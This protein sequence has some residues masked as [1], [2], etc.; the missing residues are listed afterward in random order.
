MPNGYSS[1]QPL[2]GNALPHVLRCQTA[3]RDRA[4]NGGRHSAELLQQTIRHPVPVNGLGEGSGV[5][6]AIHG[7][8]ATGGDVTFAQN[9][10]ASMRRT[11][12]PWKV[13]QEGNEKSG[14]FAAIRPF[15]RISSAPESVACQLGM[16]LN[17]PKSPSLSGSSAMAQDSVSARG[18]TLDEPTPA[19][20]QAELA[21]LPGCV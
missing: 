10:I 16:N 1:H 2:R 14:L 11:L 20:I 17:T 6:P 3:L 19:H 18:G 8:T 21:E 7:Y 9:S 12:S 5:I 13:E 15:L 4:F